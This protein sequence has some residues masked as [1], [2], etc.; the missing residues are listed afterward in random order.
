MHLRAFARSFKNHFYGL[1]QGK[2]IHHEVQSRAAFRNL[3]GRQ[4]LQ[5]DL[6][7]GDTGPRQA[8][9]TDQTTVDPASYSP[10]SVNRA[11][12]AYHNYGEI[13][14]PLEDAQGTGFYA[15]YQLEVIAKAEQRGAGN[16]E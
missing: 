7:Y 11:D 16:G 1:I 12:N 3:V 9:E 6:S 10:G 4:V 8:G 5:P 14:H 2:G 15:L 13:S